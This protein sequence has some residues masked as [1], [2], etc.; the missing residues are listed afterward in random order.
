MAYMTYI[1]KS[2]TVTVSGG[3]AQDFFTSAIANGGWLSMITLAKPAGVAAV[4]TAANI[5]IANSQSTA[6][7]MAVSTTGSTGAVVN[8]LPRGKVTDASGA[9]LGAATGAGAVVGYPDRF[10]VGAGE[11]LK[12]TVSCATSAGANGASVASA[13]G[14]ALT[15]GFYI[16]N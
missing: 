4:S 16:G 11:A 14:L 9:L 8:Y 13:G 1:S 3:A 6:V 12:I 7:L 5:V 2:I 10:P 15:L